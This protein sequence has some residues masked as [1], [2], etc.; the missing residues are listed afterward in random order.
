MRTL[1]GIVTF[2]N[3]HF[4]RLAIEEVRRTATRPVD[5]FCIVGKPNDMGQ[6]QMLD[7]MRVKFIVHGSNIGFPASINDIYDYAF[8]G[9]VVEP[10]E[11]LIMMGNDVVP[12]PGA[13]DAMIET[14]EQSLWEWVCASQYD[15]ASLVRDH[16]EARQYFTEPNFQFT[17]FTARPW[18]LHKDFREPNIEPGALRDVRNLALFK[19]SVFDKLG[20]ADANFWPGGYFEDNDY[21]RRANLAGI[22]AC[23][24]SHAAYFHFWS[25]TIHQQGGSTNNALFERNREYYISKWGGEVD[26][27]RF[28]SPF[29]DWL[30]KNVNTAVGIG[31]DTCNGMPAPDTHR[32]LCIRR[33]DRE[34]Q[35]LA[36]WQRRA[37][38]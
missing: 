38:S 7:A 1:I 29:K 30:E 31:N 14:A 22:Q 8:G 34:A 19:R 5:L 20:Y 26:A 32:E 17:N 6:A 28:D 2:G 10:Y 21:A 25:R 4:T 15:V 12:Y 33:R 37:S 24:L 35:I 16:P 27:E 11:A 18:D 9:H 13:I 3:S 36:Y 23:T